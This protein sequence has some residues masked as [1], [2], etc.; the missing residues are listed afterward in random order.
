MVLRQELRRLAERWRRE[1]E[2]AR[3]ETERIN[4]R[5]LAGEVLTST[6]STGPSPLGKEQAA[7]ELEEVLHRCPSDSMEDHGEDP[8]PWCGSPLA[9]CPE[10]EYCTS[11][12]CSYAA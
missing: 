7:D 1:C 3:A 5:L 10:G 6:V 8:C 2:E 9:Y 12:K 4:A 11:T